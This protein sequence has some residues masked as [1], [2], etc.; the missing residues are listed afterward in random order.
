MVLSSISACIIISSLIHEFDAVDKSKPNAGSR[1]SYH[2][3]Y[4]PTSARLSYEREKAPSASGIFHVCFFNFRL[5]GGGAGFAGGIAV[6]NQHDHPKSRV[7]PEL[8]GGEHRNANAAVPGGKSG[9]RGIPVYCPP[10]IDVIRI[11]EQSERAF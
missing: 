2:H 1:S 4:R 6:K 9:S 7:F 3:H 5:L 11:V 10:A 8:A